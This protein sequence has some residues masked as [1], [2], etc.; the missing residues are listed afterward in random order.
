MKA[1]YETLIAVGIFICIMLM[2]GVMESDLPAGKQLFWLAV[3]IGA[4][5]AGIAALGGFKD[6]S[7]DNV[8]SNTKK[9]EYG[10]E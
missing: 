8:P 5:T 4:I 1:F 2:S 9:A 10:N 3:L 6:W 7:R